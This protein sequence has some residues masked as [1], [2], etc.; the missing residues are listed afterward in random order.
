MLTGT[1]VGNTWALFKLDAYELTLSDI[2]RAQ[3]LRELSAVSRSG[4]LLDML[5]EERLTSH[6]QPIVWV[7]DATEV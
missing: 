6:F 1:E 7:E 3:L 5:S 2:P 4:W